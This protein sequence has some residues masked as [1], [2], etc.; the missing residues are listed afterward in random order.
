MTHHALNHEGYEITDDRKRLDPAVIHGYLGDQ[1]YWAKG[2]SRELV[3]LSLANSLCIGVYEPDGCQVGLARIVTD[4]AT[5]AWLCDVF[6]IPEHRGRG[7]GKALMRAVVSHP[8][9]QQVRRIALGTLDAHVLYAQ[10]GF[11]PLAEPQR[12]M[13]RR[14]PTP[15]A[16]LHTS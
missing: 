1:S 2:I 15:A 6:I 7:L 14:R 3:E 5:F 13:E 12:H 10:F 11:T 8:Q 4:S 9:L 16:A